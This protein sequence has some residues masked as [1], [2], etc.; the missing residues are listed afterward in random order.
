METE[1]TG[2][3]LLVFKKGGIFGDNAPTI[4]CKTC[5]ARRLKRLMGFY[6][7]NKELNNNNNKSTTVNTSVIDNTG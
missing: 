2:G 7:A 5:H 3:R 1:A 6:T 4:S